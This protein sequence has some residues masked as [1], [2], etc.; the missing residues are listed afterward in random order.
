[1]VIVLSQFAPTDDKPSNM[2]LRQM[3]IVTMQSME[4]DVEHSVSWF[5]KHTSDGG[6]EGNRAT[7]LDH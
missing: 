7:Y 6:Q 2:E 3:C 1:M 5:T 4:K